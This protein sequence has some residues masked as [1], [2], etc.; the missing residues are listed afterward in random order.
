MASSYC[1]VGDRLKQSKLKNP[2]FYFFFLL[3]GGSFQEYQSFEGRISGVNVW[4]FVMTDVKIAEMSTGCGSSGNGDAVAWY[5]FKSNLYGNI[6]VVTPS[7]CSLS[8]RNESES[9]LQVPLY[10][11]LFGLQTRLTHHERNPFKV[12]SL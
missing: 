6:D 7:T 11:S 4:S 1:V 2:L 5:N 8:G 3:K 10:V 12:K 9:R